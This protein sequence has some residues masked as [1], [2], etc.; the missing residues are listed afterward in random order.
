MVGGLVLV[1]LAIGV[2]LVLGGRAAAVQQRMGSWVTHTL[3]VREATYSFRASLGDME[4]IQRLYLLTGAESD[5]PPFYEAVGAAREQ[6][7]RVGALTQD[8]SVRLRVAEVAELLV[9]RRSHLDS[10]IGIRRARGLEAARAAVLT[11][12]GPQLTD[13]I[14]SRIRAMRQ[15]EDSLLGV[16][17]ADWIAS[18]R[19]TQRVQIL[20][21]VLVI[22][23][24]AATLVVLGR[25][26]A[27]RRRA[28]AERDRIITL[29]EDL[30][31]I[32]GF[33]GRFRMVNP[34][35]ERT[36]GHPLEELLSRPFVEFIHPDDVAPTN[37]TYEEQMQ[38]GKLV[39]DFTNRYRHRDG[40]YRWLQW[41]AITKV[42][43]GLI[44]A[45]ARDVTQQREA[46]EERR[47]SEEHTR[48][49]NAELEQSVEELTAVNQELEAFSYSVSHD[50]RAPLRHIS[51]FSDLL[52][53]HAGDALDEKGRRYLDTVRGAVTRM[54]ALID[55]LLTFSRIGRGEIRADVVRLDDVVRAVVTDVE[56]EVARRKV[57]LD[58][59]PL[60]PVRGDATLLQVAMANLLS[61]ALKY[62][63]PRADARIEV[64]T[65][66]PHEDRVVVFVRDNGVGFD[67]QYAGKL[68]GVFQRLHR[69]D[70]FE[71]TGI[72]LAT[73]QRIVHKHK[74]RVW[75]EGAVDRG[76]T[77]YVALPPAEPVLGGEAT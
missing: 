31:C 48:Q 39:I 34:V 18:A 28:Q 26:T 27:A 25:L 42:N 21:G 60:P 51:G 17:Q 23:L 67:M 76:A 9:R 54:G 64:G 45:T 46:D 77:F 24:V 33:D 56:D 5:L 52:A 4:R 19:R 41:R 63:R 36:L 43:E 10:V 53:R 37:Q 75:G 30:H 14:V 22:V 61:N 57:R 58:V 74:G 65:D 70:Q 7:A 15:T 50:L 6:L 2:A 62:T 49:L 40:S 55:D 66:A 47:R 16:R 59:R 32:A 8:S 11:R 13:A 71:G 44:Y 72:G 69:D 73:V 1:S 38:A 29:S 68:F 12:E 35:W 20:A 3:E